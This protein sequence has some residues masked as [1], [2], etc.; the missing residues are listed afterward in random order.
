MIG[1][2]VEGL[3]DGIAEVVGEL[4]GD[5]EKVRGRSF[6][7]SRRPTGALPGSSIG[8]NGVNSGVKMLKLFLRLFDMLADDHITSRSDYLM[9]RVS[10]V[11][12]ER[13]FTANACFIDMFQYQCRH[14]AYT[15]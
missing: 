5:E 1:I 7:L 10:K 8:V 14:D 2:C 11:A 9:E 3:P 13:N 15:M 12:D 6:F 4:E